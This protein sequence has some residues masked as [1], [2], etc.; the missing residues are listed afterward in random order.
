MRRKRA[1]VH[2]PI[3]AKAMPAYTPSATAPRV[4][5]ELRFSTKPA[6]AAKTAPPVT[7]YAIAEL[8]AASPSGPEVGTN[9]A[10]E[11]QRGIPSGGSSAASNP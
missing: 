5:G 7:P 10:R 8:A 4:T 3:P 9:P 2:P 6:T 11:R 1:H